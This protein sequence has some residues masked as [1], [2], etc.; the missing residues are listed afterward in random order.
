MNIK[1]DRVQTKTNIK[2]W[3]QKEGATLRVTGSFHMEHET[4]FELAFRSRPIGLSYSPLAR[5]SRLPLRWQ[6]VAIVEFIDVYEVYR[7]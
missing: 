2:L 4:R 7:A 5:R 3:T 6:R 1:L